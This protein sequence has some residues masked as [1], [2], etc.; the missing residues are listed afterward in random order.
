[1]I[2]RSGDLNLHNDI[3]DVSTRSTV[4]RLRRQTALRLLDTT[5]TTMTTTAVS[6]SVSQTAMGAHLSIQ[7]SVAR[8]RQVDLEKSE[9]MDA[10][11]RG[12]REGG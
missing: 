6:Q 2:V 4:Q 10:R 12:R 8:S 3:F 5:T 11:E 7:S 1:M 9:G